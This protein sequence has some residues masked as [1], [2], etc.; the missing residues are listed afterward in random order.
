M[1]PRAA[2]QGT[3]TRRDIRRMQLDKPQRDSMAP[4]NPAATS[5]TPTGIFKPTVWYF[6]DPIEALAWLC[7]I[8]PDRAALLRTIDIRIA[9][10][11]Q[12][13]QVFDN[14]L[15]GTVWFILFTA[16]TKLC[17]SLRTLTVY[18]CEP[19]RE[20][21][22]MGWKG[23]GRSLMVARGLATLRELSSLER[24]VLRG[25][26]AA[27][28]PDYLNNIAGVPVTA[29]SFPRE[30]AALKRYQQGTDKLVPQEK[31]DVEE[32]A[33]G[34]SQKT[35][36]R[37]FQK[38]VGNACDKLDMKRLTDICKMPMEVIKEE[39]KME[40]ADLN[41][42]LEAALME[43]EGKEVDDKAND[44]EKDEHKEAELKEAEAKEVSDEANDVEKK[45]HKESELNEVEAMEV[46]DEA[47]D[48]EK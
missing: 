26:Y 22:L 14:F 44:V 38:I 20:A 27:P 46:D 41:A 47:K 3:K 39:K 31:K 32:G 40:E 15:D 1:A 33:T 25:F 17:T 10:F 5:S 36:F 29:E 19:D 6:S 18:I 23:Y 13:W 21:K 24:F 2:S 7:H 4:S 28:W 9:P 8:G 12:D 42:L 37:R 30:Q 43:A 35:A 48:V 45:E 11:F 34:E 16:L